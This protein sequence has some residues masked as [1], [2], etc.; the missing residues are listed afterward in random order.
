M[1]NSIGHAS[2]PG[3]STTAWPPNWKAPSSKLVRVRIDGLK[4]SSATDLP[5]SWLPAGERLKAAAWS[6]SASSSARLESWVV[7]KWRMVTGPMLLWKVGHRR[8]VWLLRMDAREGEPNKKPGTR[9]GFCRS[10]CATRATA[11]PAIFR[12][13]DRRAR[14]V[15][16]AAKRALVRMIASVKRNVVMGGRTIA[17]HARTLGTPMQRK[18]R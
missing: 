9:P 3:D 10:D 7:M 12:N 14:E 13:P 16:P 17:A 5:A 15:I 18:M 8:P 6:S 1:S 4:N 11:Y 2:L